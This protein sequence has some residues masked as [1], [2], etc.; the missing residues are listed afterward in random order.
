MI[1][2]TKLEKKQ[3]LKDHLELTKQKKVKI[4]YY[5]DSNWQPGHSGSSTGWSRYEEYWCDV[6]K[7]DKLNIKKY[8]Y[9]N[10]SEGDIVVKI[11]RDTD[12][13]K[14]DRY[15]VEYQNREY[16]CDTGLIVPEKIDDIPLYYVLVGEL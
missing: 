4:K 1:G 7:V 13:P 14:V 8:A 12:L 2:L 5:D 9:G 16:T 3:I 15:K 11:P 10:L 6:T